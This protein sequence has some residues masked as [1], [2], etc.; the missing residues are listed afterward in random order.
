MRKAFSIVLV[1][2]FTVG[3]I[4]AGPEKYD[5][6]KFQD[7]GKMAKKLVEANLKNLKKHG[8]TKVVIIECYGEFLTSREVEAG[9][10]EQR[11]SNW[12]TKSTSTIELGSDYYETVAN[13]MFETT[14]KLFEENGIE[15]VSKEVL[16]ENP[17]YIELGLKEE[18]KTRGYTGGVTKKSVTTEGIKRSTTG[19]GMVTGLFSAIGQTVKLSQLIPKIVYDTGSNATVKVN[20]YVDKAKNGAPILSS[21]NIILDSDLKTAKAGKGKVTYYLGASVTALSLKNGVMSMEDIS[22]AEKGSVDMEKYHNALSEIVES[23]EKYY[24]FSIKEALAK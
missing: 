20:F 3:I 4:F 21:Y 24:S 15:V 16:I 14:K 10:M 19:M 23:V 8:V 22:G 11:H 6:A 12:T 1:L 5:A 2:V 9:A 18:K 7:V 13:Y 17:D